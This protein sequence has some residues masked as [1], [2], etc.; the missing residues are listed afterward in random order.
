MLNFPY[1]YEDELTYSILARAS[2]HFCSFSHKTWL[3]LTLK[4]RCA[5]A[6]IDFPSHLDE[7]TKLFFLGGIS[8]E[9]LIYQH[10]LFPLCSPFIPLARKV[11]CIDWMKAKSNG[12]THLMSGWAASRLPKLQLIRYC[13]MC[14]SEQIDSYG[15]AYWVRM[16][17]VIGLVSCTKHNCLLEEVSQFNH[18]RH[19]H[20]YYPATTVNLMMPPRLGYDEFDQRLS[21]PIQSLLNRGSHPSPSYKQWTSYYRHLIQQSQC[22]KGKYCSFEAVK[23][24][25]LHY[26]PEAWLKQY[27][28]W[29]LDSSNSWLHC[30]TRKHRK[31]FSYL[32][33]I[34]ILHALYDGSW[35]I[36]D[37]LEDVGSIKNIHT[38]Q[39][40]HEIVLNTQLNIR[41]L[42]AKWL[43]LVKVLGTKVARATSGGGLYMQLYRNQHSWLMK[44]N[45][46]YRR[47]I[48]NMTNRV[49][50]HQRDIETTKRLIKARDQ[51]EQDLLLP[52]QSKLWFMQQLPNKAAIEKNLHKLPI[53]NKFLNV[54]QETVSEYQIR[55]ITRVLTYEQS[56]PFWMLIKHAGL[57]EERMTDITR[58]LCE[59]HG[60]V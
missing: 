58:K 40:D 32:E 35:E 11:K 33:H 47:P 4:N 22:T 16:H 42:K 59:L 55:R 2:A 54:Y 43:Q 13:P 53:T 24:K 49:N 18:K 10:T 5:I 36:E 46:R 19:R 37:V 21:L 12:G 23:E 51:V 28:L 6:T 29:P 45:K 50:W 56:L 34:V 26:W 39:L 57:S 30:I 41:E 44:L 17:Q 48:D 14:I 52:R 27:N 7:L 15:E 1:P 8:S 38:P 25:V 3:E 31:S 60:F 20:E 9:L